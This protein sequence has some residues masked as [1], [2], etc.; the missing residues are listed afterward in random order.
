HHFEG[1]ES[2]GPY[3]LMEQWLAS[4]GITPRRKL[5]ADGGTAYL[6][7]CPFDPAHTDA[8]LMQ[9]ADGKR[10]ARC[11]GD[12]CESRHWKDFKEKIGRP[13]AN[14]YDP[15]L[16]LVQ[17]ASGGA[18]LTA[19]QTAFAA[20]YD[21]GF[22]DSAAFAAGNFKLEWL[23]RGVLVRSQPILIGG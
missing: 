14:D 16:S 4:H 23:V 1:A 3:L 15:P 18:V 2:S 12:G 5:M 20:A 11:K 8:C 6:I 13:E 19:P 9:W 17:P 21:P 10:G 22:L 7:P